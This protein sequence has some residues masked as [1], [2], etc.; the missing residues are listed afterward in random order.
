MLKKKNKIY[1][2]HGSIAILIGLVIL[3]WGPI[4]V[5][6]FPVKSSVG[7]IICIFGAA[8]I[9]VELFRRKKLH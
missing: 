3:I 4:E 1:F 6:G 7:I 8:V 5:R 9:L 2:I